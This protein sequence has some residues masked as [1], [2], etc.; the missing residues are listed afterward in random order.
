MT[1]G[2][3]HSAEHGWSDRMTQEDD[4]RRERDPITRRKAGIL[5]SVLVLLLAAVST[6]IWLTHAPPTRVVR[7]N[8]SELQLPRS[9]YP[10][11]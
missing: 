9:L 4:V 8:G 7:A 2:I 6:T 10:L 5:A 11:G 3:Q 1:N